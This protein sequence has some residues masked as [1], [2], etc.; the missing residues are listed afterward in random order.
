MP[1]RIAHLILIALVALA[2]LAEA[3]RTCADALAMKE[4]FES[5][6]DPRAALMELLDVADGR[7]RRER[8]LRREV[9]ALDLSGKHPA[10]DLRAKLLGLFQKRYRFRQS[11]DQEVYNALAEE[12][13]ARG[14]LRFLAE[15]GQL[16][17]EIT[18]RTTLR[19]VFKSPWFH[20]ALSASSVLGTVVTMSPGAFLVR[21][22]FNLSPAELE[23][24]LLKG[25][26]SPEGQAILSRIKSRDRLQRRWNWFGRAFNVVSLGAAIVMGSQEIQTSMQ[27]Q[28]QAQA[29]LEL[30][31]LQTQLALIEG[32]LEELPKTRED[33]HYDKTIEIFK[34]KIG[35]DPNAD[36][37]AQICVLTKA[38]NRGCAAEGN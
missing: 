26:E 38:P 22:D 14:L 18:A 36:E 13:A 1:Q 28:A 2:P 16:T 24:L 19:S 25:Q 9:E 11:T 30:Q 23:T 33:M 3:A 10:R 31:R 12:I 27:Q 29:D 21:E 5:G 4:I 7:T 35:R 34:V 15:R 20:R 6:E 17:N 8:S 32:V 37:L